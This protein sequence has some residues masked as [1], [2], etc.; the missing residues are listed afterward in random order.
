MG[1]RGY[2]LIE[3]MV[4]VAIMGLT[5][6]TWDQLDALRQATSRQRTREALV[7][8]LENELEQAVACTDR[9]CLA[10]WAATA[11]PSAESESWARAAL[12]RELSPGAEGTAR[13]RVAAVLP[14]S[15]RP[16]E[17]WRLV[18]VAR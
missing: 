2:T 8:V 17:A 18:W 7:R 9:A 11:T 3:L 13:V 1:R 4:T 16:V 6:H 5:L 15:T 12:T 14:G 10:A